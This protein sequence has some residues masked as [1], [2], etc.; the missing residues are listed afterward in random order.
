MDAAIEEL[1]LANAP[2]D[3]VSRI[4]FAPYGDFLLVSS[5][6]HSLSLYDT[7]QNTRKAT[8]QHAGA[9][10]DCSFYSNN[11][12]AFTGGLDQAVYFCNFERETSD[13]IGSHDQTVRTL[14]YLPEAGVVCSGSWDCTLRLWDPR[15]QNYWVATT[16]LPG[17]AHAMCASQHTVV[18]ATSD[19]S[20]SLYDVRNLSDVVSRKETP[21]K[22]QTR[23]LEAMTSGEGYVMSSIEGRVGVEFFNAPD[24]Q[25]S[26]KCHRAEVSGVTL[27]YSVNALAFHPQFNS[28]ATGGSDG[29]VA[30]WDPFNK[31]RLW[32]L[33][34]YPQAISSVSFSSSG[35]HLAIAS[36]YMFEEGAKQKPCRDSVFIRSVHESDVKCRI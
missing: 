27:I 17:K 28:F 22:F 3:S 23:A 11:E 32:K 20:V 5:W 19:K 25:Y 26:F 31:K 33:R 14:K 36:S 13:A 7:T 1:E 10:L 21:L 34:Q 18:V 12:T 29:Y 2:Q 8:I 4:C 35:Q 30:V 15:K 6:D 9:L 24:K 16:Q